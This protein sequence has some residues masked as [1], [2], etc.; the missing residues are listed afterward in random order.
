MVMLENAAILCFGLGTGI[1][2]ALVAILPNLLKGDASIP[3]LSLAGT[4]AVV[5]AV[6]LLV[7]LSAVRAT[8]R[9][10]LL[11]ALRGE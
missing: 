2:A 11:E 5:L 1:L 7:G 3:W 9:A 6:G 8:L 4:L 10:P